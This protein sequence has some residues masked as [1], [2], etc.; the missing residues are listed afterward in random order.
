MGLALTFAAAFVVLYAVTALY[1]Y[2]G[3][4]KKFPL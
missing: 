3:F 2:H 1:L 4:K